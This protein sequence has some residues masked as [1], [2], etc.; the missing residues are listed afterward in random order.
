NEQVDFIVTESTYGDRNHPQREAARQKFRDTVLHAVSD[1]GKV[2]IP[3]F[4]IGR[5]QEVLYDLNLLVESGQLPGVP[6]I[7]DGPMGLEATAL[8]SKYKDC[9]DEDALRLLKAGDA[10]LEF[11]DLYG[12]KQGRSSEAIRAI[13]GAAIIIAGSGMC[14]GGRILGH[15]CEYL[16]DPRTDV[17]F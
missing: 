5:T 2:L 11:A 8:Y 9:Y 16:P 14:S 17:I 1:G 4:A 15:L 12:A 10:P 3:A 13:K 6:V 7:V